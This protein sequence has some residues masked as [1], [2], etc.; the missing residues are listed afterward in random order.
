MVRFHAALTDDVEAESAS[1]RVD[2]PV[3]P[4]RPKH[5]TFAEGGIDNEPSLPV[6]HPLIWSRPTA[7]SLGSRH[8]SSRGRFMAKRRLVWRF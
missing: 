5:N 8:C 1:L 6:R 2:R 4:R 3:Y 7:A